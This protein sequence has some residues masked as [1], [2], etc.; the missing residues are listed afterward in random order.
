MYLPIHGY[1][2]WLSKLCTSLGRGNNIIT[3][4]QWLFDVRLNLIYNYWIK[5]HFPAAAAVSYQIPHGDAFPPPVG[6]QITPRGVIDAVQIQH[7]QPVV[8]HVHVIGRDEQSRHPEQMLA[9]RFRVRPAAQR[10]A[11]DGRGRRRR[12]HRRVSWR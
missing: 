7:K 11:H 5:H 6:T 8:R 10:G 1:Y 2:R 4:K 3:S 12:F 9:L